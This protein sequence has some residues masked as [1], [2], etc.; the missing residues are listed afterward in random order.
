MGRF[1]P[2]KQTV[3]RGGA[4]LKKRGETGEFGTST[5]LSEAKSS[6]SKKD[7]AEIRRKKKEG[8]A[9]RIGD[10]RLLVISRLRWENREVDTGTQI[11]QKK[12]KK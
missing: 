5:G 11:S 6:D 8:R 2:R 10:K 12:T 9:K 1:L 4:F 3:R 7:T